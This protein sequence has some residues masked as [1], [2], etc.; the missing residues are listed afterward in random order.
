ME[1]T[2][3]CVA[4]EE[5]PEVQALG[6]SWD[7]AAKSWYVNAERAPAFSRWREDE[8]RE[9]AFGL[10]SDQAFV[11]CA[12]TP[13]C[14]CHQAMEVICLYADGGVD[15]DLGEPLERFTVS[16]LW[17]VDEALAQQLTHWPNFRQG[18]GE[19]SGEGCLANHCPHCGAMQ[20]DYRLHAEPGDVFF[21][22]TRED[23]GAVQF[24]PLT[25]RI[26]LSGDYGFEV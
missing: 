25:G 3:L 18:V 14:R 2:Y 5:Y 23:P 20:E 16:N 11:A 21:G 15:V 6:A 22:L 9:A 10:E 19:E 8:A 7:D 1:R 24:I 4:P 26:Q 17:A 13:C 12:S